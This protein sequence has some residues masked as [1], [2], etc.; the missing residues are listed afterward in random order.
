[1]LAG[2]EGVIARAR[3]FIV[4]ENWLHRDKPGLTLDPFAL[5][6]RH[7]YRFFYPGWVGAA[8]DCIRTDAPSGGR[9]ELALIP[10]LPV[11]RFQLPGQLNVLAVPE[12]KV[13]ELRVRF[14]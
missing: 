2:A 9:T 8:A 5:L 7:G 10:F 14:A 6:A 13:G 11:Q 3:P 12:D 1:M 4:F